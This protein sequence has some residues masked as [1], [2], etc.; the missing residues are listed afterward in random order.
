MAYFSGAETDRGV[1]LVSEQGKKL[2]T[3]KEES[4]KNFGV[5]TDGQQLLFFWEQTNAQTN[6][7]NL[8]YQ[9]ITGANVSENKVMGTP[10]GAANPTVVLNGNV[11]LVAYELKVD[12]R[13][14]VQLGQVKL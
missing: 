10:A 13:S 4:A 8:G 5:S 1:K 6:Q 11:A 14:L 2:T 9:V 7:T 3:P 12:G